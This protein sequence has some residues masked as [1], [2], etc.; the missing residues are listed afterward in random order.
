MRLRGKA[1]A[2]WRILLSVLTLTAA[3]HA[4]DDPTIKV[5]TIKHAPLNLNYFEDSNVIL[6]QDVSE[7]NLYRSEDAGVTW[8][9]VKDIPENK[10]S[11]LTMHEFDKNRA[12]VITEGIEHFKTTDR[13]KTWQKFS[14]G[15]PPNVFNGPDILHFHAGDADRVIFNGADC[16]GI[17]C[18]LITLYTTDNFKS[19]PK[20]LRGNTEGCWWAKSSVLF[21]TGKEDLDKQR[22]LCIVRDNFS[23]FKE[24][25]RLLAS[26][27]FFEKIDNKIQ[28]FEPDMDTNRGVQGIVN[29]AVVKKYLMVATSSFNTDEMALFVTDDTIKWHRAMFPTD[30]GH[31]V[32]QEAYTV[33]ESTNYSIQIDVMNTRPSN[34]T[35]VMFTSNSNGTYFTENLEHTNRNTKGHV[36]FEKI[37]G[38]QGIFMVNTVK[39]W[40]EVEKDS[41]KN[42]E[43][44]QKE[45]VSK[46]TFDD[47]RNF[48][49][50]K[51][52]DDQLHLHSVT[53]LDNVGRVFTS[54]APGLV[55]G[56][57][58]KG[59]SL[60]KFGDGDV[61]VSDDA[62]V[63]WKKALD[64]PHKY[65]FGDQGSILVAVKDS[66]K[67]DVGEIRYS[68]DHG[69]SWKKASLPDDLKI[70][71]ELLTTTQDST[72]LKFLLVG[73]TGGDNAKFHMIVLDFEGLHER[74]CKDDDMEDWHARLDDNGKPSCLMGHKQTYR[75]RKKTADCF[76]NQEFKDPVPVTEDCECTDADFEC[77]YNFVKDGDDCKKAGPIVAPDNACKNAKPD[78]TFKGSSGW[79]KIP[80][81]T[82]K[83]KDG[84]QKDD[85]VDRK[86]SDVVNPPS[87][88]ADGKIKAVQHVFKTDKKDFEKIYL[89]RG[90]SSTE[91]DET[92]IVR[93]VEYA[94][95][96]MRADKQIWRTRDHGKTWDKILED[97]DVRGIYPHYFFKDVVFFTTD[98][99]KVV[100]TIDRAEHFHS[101]EAPT[102]PGSSNPLSFHPDKKD[103][104]I[105]VGEKCEKVNGKE[106]CF[107][108]ASISRDR[109]DNWK[110]AMRYVQKCEFT[111][112]SAYKFRDLRQI[113][114]LAHKREDDEKDNPKVIV[115][116]ND[117]FDEDKEYHQSDVKDFATMAEFIVVAAEDKEKDGLRALASLDGVSYAE[118]HF[119]VNFKV[120]HQNAYTVLDSS[121]HA[122][123][124]FVAT[125]TAEGRR[126]G[127]IIKSNSNG[128]SYVMSAQAV[129]CNDEY[130][131]DFEKIPGLEGVALINTVANRDKRNEP[132]KVQ[133]QIS[134]NDGSQWAFLPPPKT[135]VD[136]KAYSCSSSEGDEKC[137]LHLHHY[138]ERADKKKTFSA[139]T[140]VGLMFGNGN[141][142]SSLSAIKEADTFMTTDAGITWKNV[143][144][145]A[146]TWQY[147]D[148]GSI[149]VLVQ[150][151]SPENPVKTKTISYTTDE[152]KTWKDFAFTDKEVTVLDISTLRSGA[153]RN[154]LIWCKDDG[155]EM[156]SVNVDFAGL[157]DRPCK[158]D[159]NGGSDY[160]LWS[161]KHPSQPD[162]CLFGHVSK[163]LR[164]KEDAN[165]YNDARVQHLYQLQNCT[166]TRSDFECDYNYE[167]DSH[168]QCSLVEGKSPISPEQWCKENPDEVEYY[169]PTG[170]RRIPL[171]TCV[172]GQEFNKQAQAHPC[173]GKEDEFERRRRTS[174]I[175]IFFAV[176]I[177]IGLAGAIGW[178][179]YRNWN[180]KI[181]QIRLG[182]SPSFDHDAPWVKYPVIAL[183]AV[184]AVGAALPLVASALWR[185]ATSAYESVSGGGGGSWLNG[186]GNRRFTTRDSF[187]RG[188]GDYAVVDDDEG[189][190]LGDESD[191]EV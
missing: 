129:N 140:A 39:N 131:V 172:G 47:G 22:I 124:L 171:T 108:E 127:S 89:E 190:L 133:T 161:P 130:Y 64:G 117:F 105:W 3:V 78:V 88:P 173:A 150:R 10:A 170:Y 112:H 147:G 103:W 42:S 46:I 20:F 107:K 73:K 60:G 165:C 33:L 185:R 157:T 38:V 40:K 158:S 98:S 188:R 62:G 102:K 27:N 14:S 51:A 183:S 99:K 32:N 94:G 109:G 155:G 48:H 59:G 54:P 43:P 19:K 182:E 145:G 122:V 156:F 149:V 175:A 114:C 8:D 87:A 24:D 67:E 84:A 63:T 143:K 74:T 101:F 177:P 34:P 181:G 111:G 179:V 12:Y 21:T 18:D 25:N 70:K 41:N 176:V 1:A 2:S 86:C 95:N 26:D 123:N 68:L 191:E 11:L 29:L 76:L 134:H 97:E 148:Q 115:S 142:G 36:D 138:T 69:E 178:W 146:W 141:V 151:A 61:Y 160:Y 52:G 126:Y 159:E 9:R 31:K 167:L 106:S 44:V 169:E 15:A 82:C 58:N 71:P 121:T 125:E 65:E 139:A 154:F 55:L 184:V 189:E 110:T 186:R 93:P 132:K 45:I 50:L 91:V 162:N 35:G 96:S 72:S 80:G 128:T 57:G 81:N 113:V 187:A 16:I 77:D 13:G 136:G 5:T 118:A 17:F 90:E 120:G 49:D 116:S 104:L 4:K 168:K 119:P 30:H 66:N 166:C 56:I 152:G 79:R 92:I 174:G 135:D 83:R 163:Y 23:P 100:Y 7:Q 153:S 144:K 180:G 137:A 164:K 6:Y 28:E 53:D 37:T 75:R 85:P